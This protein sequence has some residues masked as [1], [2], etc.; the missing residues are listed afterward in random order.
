MTVNSIGQLLSV[1]NLI[2]H[3]APD[4]QLKQDLLVI[5]RLIVDQIGALVANCMFS[6]FFPPPH[7]VGHNIAS[8]SAGA[9]EN[10]QRIQHDISTTAQHLQ[11]R[12]KGTPL[13]LGQAL[14]KIM[15]SVLS[16]E[17]LASNVAIRRDDLVS[18]L[19]TSLI[20]LNDMIAAVPPATAPEHPYF[21]KQ[22]ALLIDKLLLTARTAEASSAPD[23]PIVSMQGFMLS[24]GIELLTANP[25]DHILRANFVE[26][27]A[28]EIIPDL[29]SNA[30]DTLVL[31]NNETERAN[32]VNAIATLQ[33][34]LNT[35]VS[36]QQSNAD[37]QHFVATIQGLRGAL[38]ALEQQVNDPKVG[39]PQDPCSFCSEPTSC[40]DATHSCKAD[41]SPN[42]RTG[43]TC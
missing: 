40:S 8:G 18:E 1:V 36:A 16:Q 19:G 39:Q 10:A 6:Y 2:T 9:L 12:V 23:L 27:A 15:D 29:V 34:Q 25:S 13:V 42:E 38:T 30:K 4:D 37:P 43:R 31:S 33:T 11:T 17:I 26:K 28:N 41:F 35:V 20:Q 3:T 5:S 21:C 7:S 14:Q 32:L 24:E 22:T